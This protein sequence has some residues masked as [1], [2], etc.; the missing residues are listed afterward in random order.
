TVRPLAPAAGS[1]VGVPL[2]E[3]AALETEATGIRA[4]Q[5]V[6]GQRPPRADLPGEDRERLVEGAG[7]VRRAE[8][9][10][11][12]GCRSPAHER[13]SPSAWATKAARASSQNAS[14]Q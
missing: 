7:D 11:R 2:A 5:A 3:E 8:H 9:R 1:P 12:P 4:E 6:R 13:T 14:T 10:R